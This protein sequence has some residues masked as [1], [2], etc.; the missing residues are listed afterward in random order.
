MK[1]KRIYRILRR[2]RRRIQRA[3]WILWMPVAVTC[4]AVNLGLECFPIGE[5]TARVISF[6]LVHSVLAAA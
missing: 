4:D 3:L 6:L 1:F 2:V 5:M